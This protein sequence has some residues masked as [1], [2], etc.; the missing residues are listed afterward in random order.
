VIAGVAIREGIQAWRGDN[1]CSPVSALHPRTD[2]EEDCGCEA[3]CTDACCAPA[4]GKE[5][6][7]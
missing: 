7:H 4:D 5:Q 1:C 3:G 2:V 6:V